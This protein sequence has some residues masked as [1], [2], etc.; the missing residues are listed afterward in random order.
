MIELTVSAVIVNVREPPPP[1]VEGTVTITLGESAPTVMGWLL[2]EA[3]LKVADAPIAIPKFPPAATVETVWGLTMVFVVVAAVM[4]PVFTVAGLL[5][6][7][8]P[9]AGTAYASPA[10]RDAAS[11]AVPTRSPNFLI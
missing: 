9:L 8:L 3:G 10:N 1:V 6:P 5:K 7:K 4:F 11:P 2:G